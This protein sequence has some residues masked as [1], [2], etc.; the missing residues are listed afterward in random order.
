MAKK[1]KNS[2]CFNCDHH[3]ENNGNFATGLFV[4]VVVG[5]VGMFLFG[6]DHGQEL[7]Q[8]LRQELEKENEAGETPID[9]TRNIIAKVVDE[10][11]QV[12]TETQKSITQTAEKSLNDELFP[13]FQRNH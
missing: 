6:T 5:S 8:N 13:K 1:S 9:Q 2:D 12:I 11:K 4:G 3:V 7:L 10:T